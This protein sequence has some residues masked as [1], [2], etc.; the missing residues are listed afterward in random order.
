M[1]TIANIIDAIRRV[2]SS[3]QKS[4]IARQDDYLAGAAVV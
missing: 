3:T 4:A 2:G 1:G